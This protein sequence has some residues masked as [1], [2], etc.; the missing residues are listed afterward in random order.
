MTTLKNLSVGKKLYAGFGVVV[1]VLALVAGTAFWGMSSLSSATGTITNV[2]TPKVIAADD[3]R[4]A[5]ADLTAWQIAYVL[6]RG[7]SRKSFLRSNDYFQRA[8]SRLRSLATDEE[9]RAALAEISAAYR[10]FMELDHPT[11]RAIASGNVKKAQKI[12]LGPEIVASAKLA[13]RAERFRAQALDEMERAN[14]RFASTRATVQIVASVLSVVAVLV[15]ALL[16]F[17]ITR[18]IRSPLVAVKE[19]A[20]RAASGDLVVTVRADRADEIGA[21]A[22]AFQT[23]LANIRGVVSRV[24]ETA[25]SLAG[26]SQQMASTSE[27]AGKA[28]GEIAHAIGEVAQGAER[29]VRAV[30]QAKAMT[31]EMREAARTGAASALETTAAA[32]QARAVSEEGVEAVQSATEAMR[33][34]R[35]SSAAV[36]AAIHLLG[37]K[38]QQIGGIVETITGIA[39]QT[40]LLALNAAIEAARAGEQGRGFA[41]VA[42][43]VRKLAEESQQAAASIAALIEE[44]Q[45]ETKRTVEVVEEGAKR[46]EDGVAVVEQAREAFLRIGSSVEDVTGRVE[47]I[48]AAIEQITAFSQKMVEGMVEVA[49]VAEQSS[50]ATEEVSAST[51][52]TSASAQEIA[53][54]AQEI[55][56]TAE[57]LERVVRQFKLAA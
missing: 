18:A 46:T 27:E 40:N 44:I 37:A 29:Q 28:V 14:A 9:N 32:Q 6:D 38:S 53:A 50:A 2:A 49:A 47:Q 42:E 56:R 22:A 1:A 5:A 54:S 24:S 30:E 55:A 43:E 52:E 48:A 16:A 51:E 4:F 13:N 21:V 11:Y 23:M 19:A 39:E 41:V 8:L 3:L 7:R 31:E 12:A 25:I 57:E 15:A 17:V 20:E 26:A 34:V 33:L 36:T 45:A 10:R 35:D